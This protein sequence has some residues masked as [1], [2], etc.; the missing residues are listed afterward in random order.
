M[1]ENDWDDVL[2]QSGF[3]GND[4]ALRDWPDE[5]NHMTSVLVS[6]A[7]GPDDELAQH[8]PIVKTLIVAE[9]D[10]ALQQAETA[11]NISRSSMAHPHRA[12]GSL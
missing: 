6:T 2:L 4:I 1:Y 11:D 5:L 10:S 7:A 12:R 8:K 9:D 3:T